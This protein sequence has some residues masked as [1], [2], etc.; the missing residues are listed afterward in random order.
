MFGSFSFCGQKIPVFASLRVSAASGE[1]R[2]SVRRFRTEVC[3][4]A[5]SPEQ[6]LGSSSFQTFDDLKVKLMSVCKTNP[7]DDFSTEEA[8]KRFDEFLKIHSH[9]NGVCGDFL[10]IYFICLRFNKI[11][12]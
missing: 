5:V 2:P 1:H 12:M 8:T 11:L 3:V 9:E 4:S 6:P 7:K 10:F